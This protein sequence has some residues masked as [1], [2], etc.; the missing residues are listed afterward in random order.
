LAFGLALLNRVGGRRASGGRP[1]VLVLVLTRELAQQL[2][3]ALRRT[4]GGVGG[5]AGQPRPGGYGGVGRV[6]PVLPVGVRR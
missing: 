3:T 1:I 4:P 5:A 6:L 2:T